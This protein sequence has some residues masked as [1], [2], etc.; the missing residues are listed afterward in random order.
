M[1]FQLV[2]RIRTVMLMVSA[3]P[4]SGFLD[5]LPGRGPL[6]KRQALELRDAA[7]RGTP[8]RRQIPRPGF[9]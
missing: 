3:C 4:E 6:A 5:V 9:R 7:S 1:A 8:V 2:R